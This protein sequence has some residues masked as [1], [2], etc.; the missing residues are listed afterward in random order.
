[1]SARLA[2]G[3]AVLLAAAVGAAPAHA[4]WVASGC[5]VYED[6]EQD[7]TG[8][9]GAIVERPM[10]FV[11][12]EVRD[13]NKSG[14]KALVGRGKTDSQGC[15]SFTVTDSSTRNLYLQ[16]LSTSTQTPDLFVRVTTHGGAV[17]ALRSATI[18]AHAPTVNVAFGTL[19]ARVDSGGQAFN[20]FDQLVMGADFVKALSGSRPGSGKLVTVKW[21]SNG[22]VTGASYLS[23]C[24]TIILR[25]FAGYDDSVLLHEW[26][27]YVGYHYWKSS[28]P[29]GTHALADCRQ[30]L[31][32]AFDEG[33]ASWFGN[34][35]RC[36]HGLPG[37]NLYLR[38]TGAAGPG[39]LQNWFDLEN[40]VQY[41]CDGAQSEVTVARSLWDLHDHA[42]TTDSTPDSDDPPHDLLSLG[43]VESWQVNTGPIRSAVTV[44]HEAFWDGWFD[45]TVANGYLPEMRT[46]FGS[47]S[48]DY[49]P[50]EY[51]P[52]D[53]TS[54]ATDLVV[55]GAC[56]PLT[57]FSDP[58]GDGKG[59]A[60][61]DVVRLVATGG[62]TYTVE[63]RNLLS[64][65][66]TALEILDTNGTTVLASNNDRAAGDESSLVTWTAPRSDIFYV[67][68]KHAADHGKYGSYDLCA[69]SP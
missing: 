4:A 24:C 51:E 45:P 21:A 35:V 38:T 6:R 58:D 22:G 50:D 42:G 9:T 18:P 1:M 56:L 34:R 20:I 5:F 47:F 11:D 19:V 41:A 66:N 48:I 65:A 63:T 26:A 60:D 29:T 32:L 31:R 43:D 69:T 59:Q 2:L 53:T 12:L 13:P 52:N 28:N 8:F 64:D 3:A 68:S 7:G 61:T 62:T 17:Y 40:E 14:S 46:L 25:D 37:C 67:R 33:R 36:H 27:H 16:A 10:R 23:G 39:N 15:F 57:Y 30:D 49:R 44:H 54:Q 55:N